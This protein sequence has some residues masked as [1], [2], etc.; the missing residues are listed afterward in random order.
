[1]CFPWRLFYVVSP[2]VCLSFFFEQ[3]SIVCYFLVKAHL[4]PNSIILGHAVSSC[5]SYHHTLTYGGHNVSSSTTIHPHMVDIMSHHLPTY[6][7]IW[8]T[9]RLF[10]ITSVPAIGAIEAKQ[11]ARSLSRTPTGPGQNIYR[12]PW[13]E[14]KNANIM[15]RA[16]SVEGMWI[17][18]SRF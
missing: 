15:Y 13:D 3:E 16:F 6:A 8:W 1:M 17:Q 4:I 18:N 12:R 9:R 5:I 14:Q 2:K 7:H 10:V 11:S